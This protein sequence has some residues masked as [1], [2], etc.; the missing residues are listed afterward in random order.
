MTDL[1]AVIQNVEM[2]HESTYKVSTGAI[3]AIDILNTATI[4][5]I[6]NKGR[7]NWNH[8]SDIQEIISV[9]NRYR[10]SINRTI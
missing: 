3:H 10:Q 7:R 8:Q 9:F 1:D 5:E 2:Y 4:K 6:E